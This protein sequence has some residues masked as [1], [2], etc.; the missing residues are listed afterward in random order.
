MTPPNGAITRSSDTARARDGRSQSTTVTAAWPRSAAFA[1]VALSL[2]LLLLLVPAARA[3]S[4]DLAWQRIYD[5]PSHSNDVFLSLAPAPAGGAYVV[6]NTRITGP[7]WLVARYDSAGQRL[8]LRIYDG[9]GGRDL[10]ANGSTADKSGNLI[11]VGTANNANMIVAKYSPGGKRVWVRVYDDPASSEEEAMYVATDAVGNVYATGYTTSAVSGSDVAL[12]K[13]SPAGKRRWVRHYSTAGGNQD[14]ASAIAVD[15]V[16]NVYVAGQS[17]ISLGYE[18]ILTLKYD[19]AGHRRWVRAWNGSAGGVDFANAMAVTG[20]GAVFVAGMTTGI[21]SERDAVALKYGPNGARQWSR[22]WTS[23][24]AF[25][26]YYSDITLLGNGD[27]AA[28]GASYG[29]SDHPWDALVTR[30]SAGGK[31]RWSRTY[32]GGNTDVGQHVASGPSGDI[33]VSG[34]S[35]DAG[36]SYDILTLKMSGAG[37]FKWAKRYAGAGSFDQQTEDDIAV[38][39]GVYVAGSQESATFNDAVLLKYKP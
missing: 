25:G 26:D 28:A 5:S 7:E 13:Y 30:L 32:D 8:W 10:H 24:G 20:A 6:G 14:S 38:N 3:A 4:G 19:P 1:V 36:T 34:Y 31:T 22:T 16:G 37:A 18:D 27:V 12:I 2:L 11:V 17:Y 23:P 35:Y 15:R 39:G 33:Y 9:P 21:S 29:T